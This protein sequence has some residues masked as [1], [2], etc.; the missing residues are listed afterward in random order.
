MACSHTVATLDSAAGCESPGVP[1]R[2]Y[3]KRSVVSWHHFN[4]QGNTTSRTK[5]S[6][7]RSGSRPQNE[8][9]ES[10]LILGGAKSH[11]LLCICGFVP[12]LVAFYVPLLEHPHS[13]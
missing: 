9:R 12:N 11:V 7:I 4:L 5:S 8:R 13:A 10:R 1:I 6:R 3:G 2:G